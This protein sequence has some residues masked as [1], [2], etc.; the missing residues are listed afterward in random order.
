[1]SSR[2]LSHSEMCLRE[3][4]S[5]RRGM[6]FRVR[7]GHSVLLMSVRPGAPY[8]D[9]LSGDGTVLLY[10]GH[11]APRPRTGGQDPKTVDQPL[12]TPNGQLTQ[13]GLFFGAAL[14]ARAG[15]APP[16]RVRVYEKL[17]PGVWTDNGVFHLVD[18]AQEHDGTRH[19]FVFRLEAVPGVEDDV[20]PAPPPP[21]SRRV[22][23]GWVKLAVWNRDGGRCVECGAD[24]DLHFALLRP[25]AGATPENVRLL[26][27]RHDP[28]EGDRSG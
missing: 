11:D 14:A 5:L 4:V 18:A 6:N 15:E 13:N 22:V 2:V 26:C 3:G 10:E 9:E 7:G 28:G 25:S 12:Q 27:A 16:E 20:S 23:P 19:V 21:E 17:R 8:R 24:E 1:M